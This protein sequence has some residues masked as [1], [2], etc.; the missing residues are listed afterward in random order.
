[1][2]WSGGSKKFNDTVT[3]SA[4]VSATGSCAGFVATIPNGGTTWTTTFGTTGANTASP[5]TVSTS[6]NQASL[7]IPA[8]GSLC[9]MVT[10]TRNTGGSPSMLYDGTVNVADTRVVPPSIVVPETVLGFAALALLIP[11]FT[12]RRRW[13]GF[14]RVR[15]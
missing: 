15:R 1:M 8:L 6:A 10:L 9:L 11:M 2:Y 14:L 13:L 5:F 7:S 12:E 4:G 3:I